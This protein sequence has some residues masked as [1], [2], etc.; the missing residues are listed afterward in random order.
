MADGDVLGDTTKIRRV[1]QE[2]LE[3]ERQHCRE[4]YMTKDEMQKST[5]R[6]FVWAVGIMISLAAGTAA[7]SVPALRQI[8]QVEA[9]QLMVM[10]TLERIEDQ[11][12]ND[13][14]RASR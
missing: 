12:D 10:K 14:R 13:N 2:V 5:I 9:K 8:S 7:Y 3:Q 1:A 11:L 6:A 4:M